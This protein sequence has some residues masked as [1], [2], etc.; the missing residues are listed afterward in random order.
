MANEQEEMTTEQAE[1]LVAEAMGDNVQPEVVTE[2]K[3]IDYS[4][5][6]KHSDKDIKVDWMKDRQK[7][8][9]WAMQ[10]YDAPTKIGTLN[11]ELEK[12]KAKDASYKSLD[13]KYGEIDSY[14]RENP[15]FWDHVLES[16]QSRAQALSD[17]S[18]PLT[19]EISGLKKQLEEAMSYINQDKESKAQLRQQQEDGE[20]SKEL[21]EIKKVYP[22]IDF[23]TP[24]EDGKSLE[25][26]VLEHAQKM[27]IQRF[28]TAFRDFYHDELKKIYAEEAK[29]SVSKAAMKNTKLGLLGQTEAPITK[30]SD[31]VKG[32]S[33]NDLERAI[34]EQYQLS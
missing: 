3:P 29:E 20:Y 10:G 11:Q 22:K 25:Y 15:K 13:T 26:K 8:E 33:Y 9:K 23:A 28:T 34:I 4:W 17:Q 27:G 6:F 5:T 2:E 30:R 7:I 1:S 16:Y 31:V 24:D 19:G 21:D 18:N 14:V 32:K 12:W